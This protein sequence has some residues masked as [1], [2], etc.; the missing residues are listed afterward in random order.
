M[1]HKPYQTKYI[2]GKQITD[3]ND[4]HAKLLGD[5]YVYLKDRLV[6]PRFMLNMPYICV[7]DALDK[8]EIWTAELRNEQ[9]Q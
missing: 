9:A 5:R 6:H 3:V 8:G 4:L 7:L 1:A 2:K